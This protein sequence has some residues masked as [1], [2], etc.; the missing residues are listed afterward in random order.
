MTVGSALA[1]LPGLVLQMQ[2]LQGSNIEDYL[3]VIMK[4]I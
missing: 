3:V 2:K 4:E 1:A